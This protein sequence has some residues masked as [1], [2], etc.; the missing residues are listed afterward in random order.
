MTSMQAHNEYAPGINPEP[1]PG[2]FNSV[3]LSQYLR[4]LLYS[5]IGGVIVM[6][7]SYVNNLGHEGRSLSDYIIPMLVGMTAGTLTG[8]LQH[9]RLDR[10]QERE[11]LFFDIIETMAITLEE[12]DAYTHGHANR[13]T[14]FSLQL[15]RAANLD[16]KTQDRLRLAAT[17]HDIGKIGIPDEILLKTTPLTREE[18]DVIKGHPDKGVRIL[19]RLRDSRMQQIIHGVRYHHERFD[20]QGYPEGLAGDEIPLIARIIGIADSFDAMTS[21]RPYRKG[22]SE[23]SALLEISLCAGSQFD[24]LYADLFVSLFQSDQIPATASATAY[25]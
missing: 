10:Q 22:M 7:I 24:P 25:Y 21:D 20:G 11:N 1:R 5:L 8:I 6:S 23:A 15:S 14:R 2:A 19:G 3:Q 9:L 4:I 18:F 17:L 12:R 16:K 13:V